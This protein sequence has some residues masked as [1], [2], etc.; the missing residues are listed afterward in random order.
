MNITCWQ[1]A[2]VK[3]TKRNPPQKSFPKAIL[4]KFEKAITL[5]FVNLSLVYIPG[6]IE[7]KILIDL[8]FGIF[9]KV[10]SHPKIWSFENGVLFAML[11]YYLMAIA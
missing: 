7:Q 10:H 4:L 5:R 9:R 8:G 11:T 3:S 2:K 1:H 6:W